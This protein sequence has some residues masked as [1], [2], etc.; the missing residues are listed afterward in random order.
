[1]YMSTDV[2]VINIV[3]CLEVRAIW[4]NMPALSVAA[5]DGAVC[6]VWQPVNVM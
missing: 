4:V 1:M 2:V 3:M 5:C 6:I